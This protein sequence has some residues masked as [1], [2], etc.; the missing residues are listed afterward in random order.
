MKFRKL[1]IAWSVFWGLAAVLLIVL[2]VRSGHTLDRL[3]WSRTKYGGTIAVT[4]FDGEC[5]FF[6]ATYNELWTGTT[7]GFN[8]LTRPEQ[9]AS[10]DPS[11]TGFAVNGTNNGNHFLMVPYWFLTLAVLL[12]TATPWIC[13]QFSLRTLL[14]AT[15]LVAVVLG[16]IVWQIRR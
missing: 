6:F 2:W 3:G 4:S 12:V 11:W 15:T 8:Y 14:I 10:W 13:R 7:H 16:L 1:R 9:F 5:E